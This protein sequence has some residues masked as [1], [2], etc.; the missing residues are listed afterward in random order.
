MEHKFT[1]TQHA[2]TKQDYQKLAG[3][4]GQLYSQL[5]AFPV[6]GEASQSGDMHRKLLGL[7]S[8]AADYAAGAAQL[9]GD[10]TI[11]RPGGVH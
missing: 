5:S 7:L 4:M 3:Q 11:V 6:A 2:P 10:I 1:A 8:V 9:S